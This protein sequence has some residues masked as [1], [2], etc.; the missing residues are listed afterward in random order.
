MIAETI[1]IIQG[2]PLSKIVSSITVKTMISEYLEVT[3]SAPIDIKVD[4][5]IEIITSQCKMLNHLKADMKTLK[6]NTQ[7][8]VAHNVRRKKRR[9]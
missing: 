6:A 3:L 4:K 1:S 2:N 9:F 5:L 8:L 7:K